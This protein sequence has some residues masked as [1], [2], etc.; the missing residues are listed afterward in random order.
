MEKEKFKN[1]KKIPENFSKL[2]KI[3]GNKEVYA[4]LYLWNY[5]ECKRLTEKEMET[6]LSFYGDM[7]KT[8]EIQGIVICSNC[9]ADVLPKE[10]E[11]TKKWLESLK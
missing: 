10:T 6:Q 1:L 5:G 8:G 9:T 11:M 4:G 2:R 7:L 3:A